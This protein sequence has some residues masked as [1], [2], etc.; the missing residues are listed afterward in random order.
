MERKKNVPKKEDGKES[1]KKGVD[2]STV[3]G[4]DPS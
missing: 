1:P 4:A 2:A 3:S